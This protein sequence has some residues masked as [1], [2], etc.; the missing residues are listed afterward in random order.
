MRRGRSK[1]NG[2]A[3]LRKGAE[4][5]A[6]K[7]AK[8]TPAETDSRDA[9]A[10]IHELQVHQ[11]EL[12]MQNEELLRAQAE[13]EESRTKYVDLYDCAP[14]GY[15]TFDEEGL[16]INNPVASYRVLKIE[17]RQLPEVLFW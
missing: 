11:I 13:I 6:S 8:G 15:L 7:R 16:I 3:R 5:L 10:L 17:K 2:I 14:V 1:P 9:D 12:E 4:K